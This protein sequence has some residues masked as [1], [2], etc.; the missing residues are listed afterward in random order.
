[1]GMDA[2]IV[3]VPADAQ[4]DQ[5]SYEDIDQSLKT[6]GQFR[7]FKDLN[8][9]I[10]RKFS[11]CQPAQPINEVFFEITDET[12]QEL[13]TAQAQGLGIERYSS[14]FLEVLGKCRAAL[15]KGY[16]LAYFVSR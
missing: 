7:S 13:E 1:M 10:E 9:L 11:L 2:W 5:L 14:Y 15:H 6:L 4:L 3:R 8:D 12:L 16:R